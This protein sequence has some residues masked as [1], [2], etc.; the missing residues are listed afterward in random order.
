MEKLEK[1]NKISLYVLVFTV[2]FENWN[3]FNLG[4]IISITYMGSILY[5]LTW[6]PLLKSNFHLKP[7]KKYIIPL[8]LLTLAGI[9]STAI[10]NIY[11]ETIQNTYNQRF[12]TLVILMI[13]IANQLY[14]DPKLIS[15]VLSVYIAS[16]ILL[17]PL[18]LLGVGTEFVGGRLK[19]F[20]ENPNG[21]GVKVVLAFLIITARLIN[22]KFTLK[23]FILNIVFALIMLNL[24]MMTG[25]RGAL[26]SVFLG[27]ACLIFY[28]K[29]SIWRKATFAI[30]GIVF[31]V[32]LFNYIMSVNPDF[33]NRIERTIDKGDTGREE[34]WSTAWLIIQDNPVFGVGIAGA[35]PEMFHYTGRMMYP[36]NVFLYILMTTG[37][38]GLIFFL[39]FIL[40]LA[41]N[42]YKNFKI[43]NEIVY[44]VMYVIVLFNMA[45]SGGAIGKIFFW[46]F[47]AILIGSTFSTKYITNN[48]VHILDKKN[49]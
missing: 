20:G 49:N 17:Y 11:A 39:M 45:K 24:I 40:A 31:S 43:N 10:N 37:I 3:P 14:N 15:K 34:L 2:T 19:L 5:I 42:L 33:S 8:L 16:I 36:H 6:L 25:S 28:M 44:L 22:N 4:G 12:L 7:L 27:I 38:I 30:G 29:T 9:L 32:F 13:L 48:H 41:R 47:F 18:V 23:K 26:A 46:F 1:V 21:L 35:V